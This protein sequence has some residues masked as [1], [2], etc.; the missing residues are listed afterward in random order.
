LSADPYELLNVAKTASQD[1]IQKAY[2]KLAKKL[3]PDLN[4]G[5]KQ[6]EEQF[7]EVS[8]AYDILGDADKR[9]RF[10]RGEIDA[11]GAE[12]PREPFYRDYAARGEPHPYAS[13][14]GFADFAADEDVLS[15]IFGRGRR[16]AGGANIRMRGADAHYRLALD[17]LDA[18]NG[19]KQQI[20][21]PDGGRLDVTIPPGTR[22]GQVLRLKGKGGAGIGGGPPGDALIEIEVRPHPAFRLEGDDIHVELAVPLRDAVLGGKV[23]VP[24]LTGAVSMTLP[25]WSNTGAMLR[26]KGKGARRAGGGHGDELV[27][28]KIV[29]PERPDAEL[30]RLIGQWEPQAGSTKTESA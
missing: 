20:T 1:D 7:K 14:E 30:E 29:L 4:P 18:L 21:L 19:G 3:H 13:D 27:T 9:A 23:R 6:A 16:R 11:A 2:R 22:D 24:T 26:L 12:R 28:I 17:F 5:N 25:K 10:D 8:A 15:Q